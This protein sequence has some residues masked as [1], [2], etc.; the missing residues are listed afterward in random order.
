MFPYLVPLFFKLF[1]IPAVKSSGRSWCNR[2]QSSGVLAVVGNEAL[3]PKEFDPVLQNSVILSRAAVQ[4]PG[5]LDAS[6]DRLEG[7]FRVGKVK[8]WYG[9]SPIEFRVFV[10]VTKGSGRRPSSRGKG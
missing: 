4:F 8:V 3:H 9:A 2:V 5:A 7:T 1:R 6:D 10:L